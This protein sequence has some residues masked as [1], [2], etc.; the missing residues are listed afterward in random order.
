MAN[1]EG[2]IMPGENGRDKAK[3][4]YILN[5]VKQIQDYYAP[6]VGEFELLVLLSLMRLGGGAYG[7]AIRREIREKTQRDVAIGTVY[8]T[9]KRLEQKKM[10][11]S[12]VGLPSPQRGGRRRRHYVMHESGQHALGRAYRTF[13]TMS[14]GFHQ[15]LAAL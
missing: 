12:Y 1:V 5:D 4:R 6:L 13:Q 2:L 15:E 9:L 11:C 14:E 8:M 7:A 3:G 10:I